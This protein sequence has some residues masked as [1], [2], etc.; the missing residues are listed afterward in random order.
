M[1]TASEHG[2]R[3]LQVTHSYPPVGVGGVEQHVEG[4][5]AALLGAGHGVTIYTRDGGEGAEGEVRLDTDAAPAMGRVRY[6][7]GD[8]K[9]FAGLYRSAALDAAFDTFLR[10]AQSAHP[11][12][13]AHV[14]HLT[15][16][17]VGVLERL[18]AA[19]IP[20][21]M[22]LHDY[23]MLC[24]R[25]QMW[26]RR[27]ELCATIE[28]GRCAE[29][30]ATPFGYLLGTD[31]VASVRAQHTD[32]L[33]LLGLPDALVVPSARAIPPFAAAGVDPTRIRVVENAVDTT[34]L[35]AVPALR[36]RP[37]DQPLR[38]GY[39]GT[40]IPSKGLDVLVTA[41][42]RLPPG[43]VSLHVHGNVVPYHGD[44]GFLTRT[45]SQLRPSDDLTFHGPYRT[46]DL[47]RILAGLDCL[48]APARWAEAYGLTPREALAA[49]RPVIVSRIG[50]LQDA[51]S[52][53]VDGLVVAP[54]DPA[55]LATAL[56]RL[57][58]EPE[59]GPAL[60][61]AGRKRPRGFG[62]LAD[63]LL[64]VYRSIAK[65]DQSASRG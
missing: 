30:L 43:A 3:V 41:C 48:V 10:E 15:G 16:L 42:Q 36:R 23:W 39:L 50:G 1:S 57:R 2:L 56:A 38:V 13:V 24:A 58:I 7:Y 64:T 12:D 28:A 5:A 62:A 14:H 52:H 46:G 45:L 25:G 27:G 11:F 31:P 34:A 4:L 26:H 65:L 17:S 33:H 54:G 61:A 51:V 37:R 49:G 18:R 40:L 63:E 19:R 60:G 47:P 20:T 59:L 9:A 29:C 32:A 21:V 35:A 53:G 44:E 22:T 8:V 55:E 6:R